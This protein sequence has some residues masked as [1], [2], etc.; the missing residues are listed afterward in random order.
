MAELVAQGKVRHLGLSEASAASLR[1]A[2][3]VHPDRGAA[4]RVVAV[5]PR[6]G[7]RRSSVAR[8]LGIGLVPFSPLGR[9]FL[10][11]AI[12]SPADFDEDDFRRNQPRF[13]GE[14]FAANLRLVEAVRELAA[15]K[16]VTAGQLAL[17]W[18]LAQGDDVVPIP[19][20][21]RRSYLEENA[22]A[23]AVELT[24]DDLD[25]LR[26][27]R[28]PGRPR[29]RAI[30][31]P[32]TP[33]ATVRSARDE[34]RPA[35]GRPP[36]RRGVRLARVGLPAPLRRR[37]RVPHAA[38]RARRR[39]GARRSGGGRGFGDLDANWPR[40]PRTSSSPTTTGTSW[41]SSCAM[42][43]PAPPAGSASWATRG[44]RGRTSRR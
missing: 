36:A 30:P 38:G 23:A 17:A 13:Q 8:E 35:R 15:E 4:E 28:R 26:P 11:G 14:A 16:G 1:R 44:T 31:T 27:S 18:V 32:A 2:V 41:G 43:W 42:R 22:G 5:D 19:G 25:R 33:T 20:T 29:A 40:A 39:P 24:A 12:T 21:K 9:G 6:P 7:E 37:P 10:T 34:H 3:A